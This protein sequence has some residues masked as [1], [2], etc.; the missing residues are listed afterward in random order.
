MVAESEQVW[1]GLRYDLRQRMIQ[2]MVSNA[3]FWDFTYFIPQVCM[4]GAGIEFE[5]CS[6]GKPR[7]ILC[8]TILVPRNRPCLQEQGF[9]TSRISRLMI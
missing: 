9:P 6:P 4:R 8:P 2:K 3:C 5:I 1:Y 7:T